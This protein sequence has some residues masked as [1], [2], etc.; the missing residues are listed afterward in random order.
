M[1][2]PVVQS[3]RKW[4]DDWVPRVGHA[5]KPRPRPELVELRQPIG[6]GPWD[7]AYESRENFCRFWKLPKLCQICWMI[8][9]QATCW[10]LD[11]TR[12]L[13]VKRQGLK[14]KTFTLLCCRFGWRSC[15]WIVP[16]PL[17]LSGLQEKGWLLF[18]LVCHSM[19]HERGNLFGKRPC[20]VQMTY[21]LKEIKRFWTFSSQIKSHLIATS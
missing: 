7:S 14:N 6:E 18:H 8:L 16:G 11:S 21:N 4:W 1:G 19:S 12:P 3:F 15:I 13:K 5:T 2:I 20:S 9:K 17:D 10:L